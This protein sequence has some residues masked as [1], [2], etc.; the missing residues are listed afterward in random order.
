[1]LRQLAC[2]TVL[3]TAFS[4]SAQAAVMGNN[5]SVQLLYQGQLLAQDGKHEAAAMKFMQAAQAD[6]AASSA[7]AA[8]AVMNYRLS[9]DTERV[10][11]ARLKLR[12]MAETAARQALKVDANDPVAEELLRTM[13]TD[14]ALRPHAPLPA[15]AAF[16]AQ[17]EQLFQAQQYGAALEQYEKAQ[18]ADPQYASAWVYAGDCFVAQQQWPQAEERFRKALQ[19]DPMHAQAWR[20]L[21]DTL[22]QQKKTDEAIAALASS[23]G[24]RPDQPLAWQK[25]SVLQDAT[26]GQPLTALKLRRGAEGSVDRPDG[27]PRIQVFAEA[28][29]P[30]ANMSADTAMWQ[31][32]AMGQASLKTAAFKKENKLSPFQ[33]ELT[34]WQ[35]AMR[36]FDDLATRRGVALADPAL[37]RMQKLYA[38]GQL[39]PALLLL[40]F[41]EA[42]RPELEAWKTAHP[43]G[44]RQFIDTQRL[45]P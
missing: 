3:S 15:A 35:Q 22:L 4:L 17:G 18:L 1:M 6:P 5:A 27:K 7:F 11:A 30:G 44:V 8:M 29:A 32:L 40:Q 28:P 21:S 37:L 43:N 41:R 2:V 24:A 36:A 42:Y 10:E 13:S 12:S 23:I 45:M 16:M 9:G 38:A 26:A 34:A 33:I 39:E 31:L 20:F 14:Q 19:I 25:L